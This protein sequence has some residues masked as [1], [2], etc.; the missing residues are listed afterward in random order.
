[1]EQTKLDLL[2]LAT[3]AARMV[4]YNPATGEMVWMPT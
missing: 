3:S 4:K 1:M 2:A